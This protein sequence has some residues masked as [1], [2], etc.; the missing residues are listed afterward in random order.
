MCVCVSAAQKNTMD[1]F[2]FSPPVSLKAHWTIP[3]FPKGVMEEPAHS[4]FGG[5]PEL[6][7]RKLCVF[8]AE[9][10]EIWLDKSVIC[11]VCGCT[12]VP[13]CVVCEGMGMWFMRVFHMRLCWVYQT[14]L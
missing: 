2:R 7:T 14:G 13:V 3:M 4:N 6:R 9:E 12:G 5:H 10:C 11:E 1:A 8:I